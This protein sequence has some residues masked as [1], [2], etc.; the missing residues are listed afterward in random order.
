MA[1]HYNLAKVYAQSNTDGDLVI[2]TITTFVNQAPI[3]LK[4]IDL[5]IKSKDYKLTFSQAQKIKP[6]LDL[7][8]MTVTYDEMDQVEM[9][10]TKQGKRKEIVDT[11]ESIKNQIEKAVK[12]IKKDFNV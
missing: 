3:N 10:A 9:W 7:L 12:E 11:I 8:G 6:S 5:S 1:I 2:K 4:E